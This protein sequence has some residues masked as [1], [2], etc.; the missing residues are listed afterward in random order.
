MSH[1][2][3]AAAGTGIAEGVPR[4]QQL[5]GLLLQLAFEPAEGA[6]ALDGARQS[7]PRSLVAE[8][9]GEVAQVLVPDVGRQ[10]IDADQVQ[11][12]EVDGIWPSIPVSDVQNATSPVCGLISHRCS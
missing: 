8:L 9:T 11:I 5:R 12:V 3:R 2:P 4:R 7:P 10:R 1:S 6:L